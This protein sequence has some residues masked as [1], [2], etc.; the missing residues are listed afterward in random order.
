MFDE[1]TDANSHLAMLKLHNNH[2]LTSLNMLA[3]MEDLFAVLL[4][5]LTLD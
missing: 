4:T 2:V 3:F 5:D 1:N